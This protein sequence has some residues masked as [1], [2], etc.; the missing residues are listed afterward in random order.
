[1]VSAFHYG[2]L[3]VHISAHLKGRIH[4]CKTVIFTIWDAQLHFTMTRLTLYPYLLF[5][6][7]HPLLL[8]LVTEKIHTVHCI[9]QTKK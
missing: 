3:V 9:I 7:P 1:M 5:T 2:S 4:L 8:Q 6:L